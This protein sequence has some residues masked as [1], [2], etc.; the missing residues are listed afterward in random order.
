MYSLHMDTCYVLIE[1]RPCKRS[2]LLPFPQYRHN[3]NN[4]EYEIKTDKAGKW[5]EWVCSCRTVCALRISHSSAVSARLRLKPPPLMRRFG[6]PRVSLCSSPYCPGAGIWL[7]ERQRHSTS[8]SGLAVLNLP[9]FSCR[10]IKRKKKIKEKEKV[11][12]TLSFFHLL[13]MNP[14]IYYCCYYCNHYQ[15]I[16]KECVETTCIEKSCA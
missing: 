3:Y 4:A 11:R 5:G 14:C 8:D 9:P 16:N 2:L 12:L 10:I 6:L 13:S 1:L 15:A 7:A